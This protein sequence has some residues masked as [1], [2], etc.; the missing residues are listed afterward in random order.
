M[1]AVYAGSFNLF[2][3]GHLY[4]YQ[5][6]CQMFGKENVWL[7]VAI[8][9][10]KNIDPDFIK[11]TLNPITPN[12]I[13]A[14]G[15]V[16]NTK[17]DILIRGLR[18]TMDLAEELTM[19]DWNR[20][21]GANTVFIPC[22]GELRHISSSV[23]RHLIEQGVNIMEG[24]KHIPHET[25][26]SFR[27]WN[28]KK[29][30][31]RKLFCGKIS[32]GKSTYLTSL[33]EQEPVSRRVGGFVGDCDD[34]IWEFFDEKEKG[35]IKKQIADCINCEDV[36]MGKIGYDAIIKEMATKIDW[37]TLFGPKY[38]HYEVSAFGQWMGLIPYD[39]LKHF[40]IIELVCDECDR[41]ERIQT[42][43]LTVE[44]VLKFDKFYKSP[45]FKDGTIDIS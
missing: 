28:Q 9:P 26:M 34:L 37:Y 14:D 13:I 10:K 1:R 40:Q 35:F 45:Y 12:V 31:K 41:L 27:R 21:L 7:C 44:Q 20:E 8:N 4:V 43:G 15:L 39:I 23:L 6:A 16:V 33:E 2:H 30:P 42:R 22:S 29:L 24:R 38:Q 11:W 17:P 3:A 19:A 25:Y 32:I 18:D 5:Q 36:K